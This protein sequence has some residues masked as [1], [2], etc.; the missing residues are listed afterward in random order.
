[1]IL[2]EMM[3]KCVVVDVVLLLTV[4]RASVTNMA[5]FVLVTTMSVKLVVAVE[6]LTT[7]TTLGVSLEATLVYCTRLVIAGLLVLTQLGR[8]EQ[9]M[10][11]SKHLLVPGTKVTV[12]HD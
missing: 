2:L 9:F 6:S 4:G 1:M 3:L 10:L 12:P 7:E 11:M 8:R 5:T